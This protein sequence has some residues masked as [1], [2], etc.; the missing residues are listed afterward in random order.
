[1]QYIEAKQF[2]SLQNGRPLFIPFGITGTENDKLL[3]M[4]DEWS[5]PRLRINCFRF[6]LTLPDFNSYSLNKSQ[7]ITN[8]ST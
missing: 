8:S 5:A 1:M 6:M 4:F 7:F 2:I 3:I